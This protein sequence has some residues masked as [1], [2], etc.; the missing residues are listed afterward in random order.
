MLKLATAAAMSSSEYPMTVA[1]GGDDSGDSHAC[2]AQGG[3]RIAAQIRIDQLAICLK[4]HA[5][6]TVASDPLELDVH[7]LAGGAPA[8]RADGALEGGLLTHGQIDG[9]RI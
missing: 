4:D 6:E 3:G 8:G 7:H 1:V 5:I 9:S 2:A